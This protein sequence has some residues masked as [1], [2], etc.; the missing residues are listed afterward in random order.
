M[1]FNTLGRIYTHQN[2]EQV[3]NLRMHYVPML[4]DYKYVPEIYQ[5]IKQQHSELDA[6]DTK[7]LFAAV[8]YKMYSPATLLAARVQNAP[9]N[10][11]KAI[12]EVLGYK[13]GTNINYFQAIARAHVKNPRY[14]KKIESI[15]EHFK[16]RSVNPAHWELG[17]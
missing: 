12:A 15:M 1:N 8:V 16:N 2:P 4:S 7:I 9:A 10:M 3:R 6:T 17:L 5:I 11:R 13:N 14:V